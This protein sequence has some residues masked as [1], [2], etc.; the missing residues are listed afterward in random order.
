[1]GKKTSY[2]QCVME[3]PIG[4]GLARTVSFIPEKFAVQ[5]KPLD[6]KNTETGKWEQGWEVKS[7][8][9]LLFD[10]DQVD[11]LSRLYRHQRKASDIFQ[12]ASP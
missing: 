12:C 1:M 8:G 2:R 7:A 10:E 9:T 5:G 4:D 3:R 11:Q 6:L